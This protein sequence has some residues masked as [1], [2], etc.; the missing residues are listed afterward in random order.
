MSVSHL[1]VEDVAAIISVT[2]LLAVW[3]LTI[4]RFVA[5]ITAPSNDA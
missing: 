1:T 3:S 5:I 2:V 4:L